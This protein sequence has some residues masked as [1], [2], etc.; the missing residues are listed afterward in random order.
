MI[1][2]RI[3]LYT[4]HGLEISAGPV[5][6]YFADRLVRYRIGGH[7]H[8]RAVVVV[9][10]KATLTEV[11]EI[12]RVLD[13]KHILF[14]D[15]KVHMSRPIMPAPRVAFEDTGPGVYWRFPT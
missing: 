9:V 15:T 4:V 1:I 2:L 13:V 12:A 14:G 8:C 5:L 7:L 10:R 6:D 3:P 11:A